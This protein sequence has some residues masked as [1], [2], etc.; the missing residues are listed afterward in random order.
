MVLVSYCTCSATAV[1]SASK[2]TFVGRLR[3]SWLRVVVVCE[4]TCS[5]NGELPPK[6]TKSNQGYSCKVFLGGVPWDVTEGRSQRLGRSPQLHPFLTPLPYALLEVVHVRVPKMYILSRR[7]SYSS[8][9]DRSLFYEHLHA[10]FRTNCS[11]NNP[12]TRVVHTARHIVLHTSSFSRVFDGGAPRLC[13]KG[14]CVNVL[15]IR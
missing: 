12:A 5:W 3:S 2:Y 9:I 6:T 1:S 14:Q 7:T 8:L 13:V 10:L 4:P 11:K 15:A